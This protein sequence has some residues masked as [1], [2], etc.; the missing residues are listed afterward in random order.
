MPACTCDHL[1][2]RGRFTVAKYWADDDLTRATPYERLEGDN[3]LLNAGKTA[4]FN[5]LAGLG[6]VTAF[7]GTNGRLCVGNGTTAVVSSQTDLVG[8]SQLRK[9]FDA[10]PTISSSGYVAVATFGTTD[11]NFAWEEA[12][13]A[14]SASGAVVLNR[15]VQSFGTKTGSLTWVLTFSAALS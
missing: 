13:V 4:I 1:R 8:G 14:N 6:S 10:T 11:A 2:F 3:L 9:P 12:A 7:D 15:V 5:R